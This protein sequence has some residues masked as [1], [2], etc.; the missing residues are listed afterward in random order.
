MRWTVARSRCSGAASRYLP[1]I[2]REYRLVR[3]EAVEQAGTARADE[4]LLAASAARMRC[5][6]RGVATP[7]TIVVS[8][9]R[10]TGGVARPVVA[11]GV[12]RAPEH[13]TAVRV[14]AGQDVVLIRCVSATLDRLA[15]LV[16]I[17]RA[18]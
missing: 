17:G 2:C 16:E 14:R 6:P 5:V 18:S 9:H 8:H 15:L 1:R 13:R 4:I 11:R 10:A 3:S 12:G 7:G